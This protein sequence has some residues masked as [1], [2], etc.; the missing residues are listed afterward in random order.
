MGPSTSRG[1]TWCTCLRELAPPLFC[2]PQG[3]GGEFVCESVE[4]SRAGEHCM[5]RLARW[6]VGTCCCIG[7]ASAAGQGARLARAAF[8]AAPP[9]PLRSNFSS[10]RSLQ[11]A[12]HAGMATTAAGG[13][14][15]CDLAFGPKITVPASHIFY[16]SG[17][18]AAFVNLKP[19]VPGHVLVVPKRC[20]PRDH[21]LSEEEVRSV[22]G[23]PVGSVSARSA[24][25]PPP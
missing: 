22:L 16:Q 3:E 25:Q 19:I 10:S 23:L 14:P 15:F 18:S 5:H 20:V 12:P 2:L 7:A 6:L 9:R 1:R 4:S 24:A 8:V 11:A 17:H 13:G 21:E